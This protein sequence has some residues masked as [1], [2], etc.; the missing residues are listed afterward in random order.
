MDPK[1]K[2]IV[3]ISIFLWIIYYIVYLL[4]YVFFL[5][6]Y[7]NNFSQKVNNTTKLNL[8]TFNNCN[9]N[10]F[11]YV[12]NKKYFRWQLYSYEC[13]KEYIDRYEKDYY[14]NIYNEVLNYL[15]LWN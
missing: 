14:K 12:D 11:C 4:A 3:E 9:S 5:D 8:V 1:L 13:K 2:K 10:Y 6:N 15:K 7:C